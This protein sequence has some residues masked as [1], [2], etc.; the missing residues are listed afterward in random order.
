MRLKEMN[1][2]IG[3]IYIYIA[4]KYLKKKNCKNFLVK[5][6]QQWLPEFYCKNTVA[7]F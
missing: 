7:T 1:Y 5:N 3:Y 4:Y 6:G 2:F